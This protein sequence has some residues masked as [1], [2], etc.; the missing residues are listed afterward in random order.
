MRVNVDLRLKDVPGQLIKALEPISLNEGN[1]VGVVH[2]HDLVTGGRISVNVTFEYKDQR[3]LDAISSAWKE[4]GVEVVKMGEIFR[5]YAAEYLLVGD[6]T[7][8]TLRTIT[9]SIERMDGV[10]TMDLQYSLAT[11]TADRSV[12]LVVSVR[13]RE[14][15]RDIDSYLGAMS[16][17]HDFLLIRGMGV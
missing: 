4:R 6:L 17:R 12:L 5:T 1:I 11:G 15:V 14:R 16:E 9:E 2:N 10:E 7:H 13:E 3:A 8:A